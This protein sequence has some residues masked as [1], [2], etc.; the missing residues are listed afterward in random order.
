MAAQ[1]QF[2]ERLELFFGNASDAVCHV[3]ARLAL[4]ESPPGL[5]LGGTLNGPS[6]LYADTLPSTIKFIDQGP[7]K[8]LLA[9]VVLPEP[10]FWTPDMPHLYRATVELRRQGQALAR[11]QRDVGI[12]TL[13]AAGRS[14]LLDAERWVLRAALADV[15]LQ[16]NPDLSLW[17]END[18]ALVV[19]HADEALCRQASRIGV[20][21]M[22]QLDALDASEFARLARHASVGLI[23]LPAD[24]TV[25]LAGKGHNVVLAARFGPGQQFGIPAW[26]Q[27]AMFEGQDATELALRI[28]ASK[29]PAIAVRPTEDALDLAASRAACD[30]LQRDLAAQCN[31]TQCDPAGY[32]V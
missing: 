8:S 13:G 5:E 16:S 28:A 27:V 3:Y 30:A 12:R 9:R 21:L 31:P 4:D 24:A 15:R 7:G 17:R 22:A 25:D 1:E 6:C 20:L 29:I 18:L 11:A 26:A 2:D 14:L 19:R 23:S 10:C 32:V